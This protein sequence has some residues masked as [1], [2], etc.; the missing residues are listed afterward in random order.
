MFSSPGLL[1]LPLLLLLLPSVLALCASVAALHYCCVLA[2]VRAVA[3]VMASAALH[4]R[5]DVN[6]G[7][8]VLCAIKETDLDP[9]RIT[10]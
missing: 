1:L 8:K 10:E 9:V 4:P 5:H 7:H 2:A 3:A 6:R